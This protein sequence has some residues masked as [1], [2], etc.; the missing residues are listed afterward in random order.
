M[1][2]ITKNSEFNLFMQDAMDWLFEGDFDNY[3]LKIFFDFTDYLI[4]IY[5][6]KNSKAAA[7][8]KMT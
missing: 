7:K 8:T 1:I 2:D 4:S 3:Y 6:N 5:L